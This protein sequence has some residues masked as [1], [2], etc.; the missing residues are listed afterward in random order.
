[1]YF[2][3]VLSCIVSGEDLYTLLI[4][5]QGG[6]PI[7]SVFLYVV[8]RIFQISSHRDKWYK[9][10]KMKKNLIIFLI[11]LIW[12]FIVSKIKI[13]VGKQYTAYIC[14]FYN[15]WKVQCGN[16]RLTL[17]KWGQNLDIRPGDW[18]IEVRVF[19]VLQEYI[20]IH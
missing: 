10:M 16:I 11:I 9:L 5:G 19:L 1:M 6:P 17:L 14:F 3:H 13:Q 8:H 4:T 12:L 2:V 7:M 20:S 18:I 15:N